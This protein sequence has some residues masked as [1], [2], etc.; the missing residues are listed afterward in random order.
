MLLATSEDKT[1]SIWNV[2][3][4]ATWSSSPHVTLKVLQSNVHRGDLS[5]D[6]SDV[7]ISEEEE[8]YDDDI[9]EEESETSDDD[10]A[11]LRAV[12]CGAFLGNESRVITGSFDKSLR[13]W[14]TSD[15]VQ[16][17]KNKC[18][19]QVRH[20]LSIYIAHPFCYAGVFIVISC[21]VWQHYCWF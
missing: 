17:A 4:D 18:G 20:A 2:P 7:D 10:D 5:D 21:C 14:R 8:S 11:Y 3:S 6:T 16:T 19:E 12:T 13:I 15:G 9:S 1:A